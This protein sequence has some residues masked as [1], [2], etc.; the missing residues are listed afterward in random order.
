[1]AEE[2]PGRPRVLVRRHV[3]EIKAET[4]V[5]LEEMVGK[6]LVGKSITAAGESLGGLL[7]NPTAFPILAG[8]VATALGVSL[9]KE[10]IESVV[11]WFTA[12][13]GVFDAPDEDA[14]RSAGDDLIDA[15]KAVID[16]F[17]PVPLP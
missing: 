11:R 14:R 15:M 5:W 7:G 6:L 10:G 13:Q 16:F 17:S 9:G 8:A 4:Q 12:I 1:M 2:K 3:L